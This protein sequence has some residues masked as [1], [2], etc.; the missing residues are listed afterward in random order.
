MFDYKTIYL[1]K[2]FLQTILN[3]NE[4]VYYQYYIIT[5]TNC[6]KKKYFTRGSIVSLANSVKQLT[7]K[8]PFDKNL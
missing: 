4:I 1:T 2:Y 6:K 5:Y 8:G 7:L 3:N